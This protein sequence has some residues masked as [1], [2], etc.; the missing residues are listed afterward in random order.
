MLG[1]TVAFVV[2]EPIPRITDRGLPHQAISSHFCDDRGGGDAQAQR[3]A[4]D[5]GGLRHVKQ[6]K[7]D[8]VNQDVI[9]V[10]VKAAY[11]LQHRH[12]GSRGDA[13]TIDYAMRGKS[14][15]DNSDAKDAVVQPFALFRFHNLRIA[16]TSDRAQ[17]AT[18]QGQD[19]RGGENRSRE[20]TAADLVDSGY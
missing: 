10:R 12:S 11:G 14:Y 2:L 4:V 8:G 13:I 19:D 20:T 1:R 6:G 5:D 18:V 17:S 15:A 3:I 16:D 9:G 7:S